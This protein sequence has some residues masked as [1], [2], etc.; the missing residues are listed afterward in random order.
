MNKRAVLNKY[1]DN[2]ILEAVKQYAADEQLK[3]PE[4]IQEAASFMWGVFIKE[5]SYSSDNL[6]DDFVKWCM[7]ASLGT[8]TIWTSEA[9]EILHECGYYSTP[10]KEANAA[11]FLHVKLSM[12]VRHYLTADDWDLIS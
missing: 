3:Q 8:I 2:H 4:T 1:L 9:I 7:G 6:Q 12:R 5:R 10:D 11:T